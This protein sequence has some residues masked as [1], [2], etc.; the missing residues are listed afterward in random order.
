MK[1]ANGKKLVPIKGIGAPR[2]VA[3]IL[4]M[5][6]I[7]VLSVLAA[8]IVFS[9]RSETFASYNYRISTQADYVAKAG[10]Q[11]ALNFFNS[12]QYKAVDPS[13]PNTTYRTSQYASTPVVLWNAT[14]RAVYCIANCPST[15]R[16]VML[17]LN[18]SGSFSGNYPTNITNASGNTIPTAFASNFYNVALNPLGSATNSGQ[19]TVTATLE[20]YFTVNDAFYPTINRK[21]YEV[22][23]VKSTGT[24]N[25][26]VGAGIA[27][28]TSVQEATLA[29]VYLPYFANALYG[30]CDITLQGT[31]CTDSYSSAGGAYNNTNPG[32]VS[33]GSTGTNAFAS[34]AGVGSGGNVT[35]NGGTYVVNG[36]VSYGADPPTYSSL[37][38]CSSSSSGV[39]GS[40]SGVTGTVQP[41]PAIPEPP[42]PTFPSCA[43]YGGSSGTSCSKN[44]SYP[45]PPNPSSPGNGQYVWTR[46]ISGVWYYDVN[47]TLYPMTYPNWSPTTG[48]TAGMVVSPGNGH[49]YNC[50]VAGTSGTTPPSPWPTGSGATVTDGGSW[51][52]WAASTA[53]SVGATVVP[54]SPGNGHVY[55]AITAGTSGPTP[56]AFPTASGGQVNDP[57]PA[58]WA[59]YTTYGISSVIGQNGHLYVA[60]TAGRSGKAVASWPTTSGATV[61]DNSFDLWAA[62]T[63]YNPGAVVKPVGGN[64]HIYAC[65]NNQS[66]KRTGSSAPSWP[67]TSG[68]TVWDNNV[69]WQEYGSDAG[70]TWV[71]SGPYAAVTW[72]EIGPSSAI[73][74]TEAGTSGN[75]LGAGTS[76]D[77]FR[78]PAISAGNGGNVCLTGG[79]TPDSAIYYDIGDLYMHGDMSILNVANQPTSCPPS[80]YTDVGYAVLNIYQE[81]DLTGQ[82]IANGGMPPHAAPAAL[83]INVYNEGSNDLT[84]DSVTLTGQANVAAVIT[85]LGGAK[86]AGS[87]AGGAFWGS[88]LAGRITDAGK[89]AVHYDQ[90]LKVLS[91]KLMPMA[92]RNYNR[93]KH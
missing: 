40:V 64:G 13:T 21:P 44:T 71:E 37:W 19:F 49:T 68:G 74:W 10:L 23:Y 89:Y 69:Q 9:A 31:V 88:L 36:D 17:S 51:S 50:T 79:A 24:W 47:G 56:P 77:P 29:P 32:C 8:S 16:P 82:G 53:Y 73:T 92:I 15:P 72:Q 25:S 91:G 12:D 83:V 84:D 63:V 52:A 78:L 4:V 22:W 60:A 75:I 28:P 87:G 70:V 46:Q 80:G 2:G 58:V 54:P 55:K 38:A 14:D 6:A 66:N 86:F 62:S 85:A 5:L 39:S 18:S 1:A 43:W 81:L 11:K 34:G 45:T 35:L 93:P 20:E 42:M 3:L 41:V 26:N 48:Y 90:S 33:A 67:T 27:K 7:L 61:V 59:Q 30:M 57:S 76:N 65:I